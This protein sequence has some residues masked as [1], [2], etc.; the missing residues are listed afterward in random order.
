MKSINYFLITALG[1]LI[2]IASI[3]QKTTYKAGNAFSFTVNAGASTFASSLAWMH[4]RGVGKHKRLK[5]GYGLRFTS[6]AGSDIEFITA[7]AKFTSG[8]SSIAALV[9]P[10]INANI[11]TVSFA[12]AQINSLNAGIYFA[13][14]LPFWK[15]KVELGVNIDAVGFS[16]GGQQKGL[17]KNN[18]VSAKPTSFNLLLISDSDLGSLNSEWYVSY[19]FT[20]KVA[21]KVGYEFLFNEYTTT[22]KV[23]QL[24]SSNQTNDRFRL[25]S[26]MIM[27]GVNF[28]PFR[29]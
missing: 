15:N 1:L 18:E 19:Q 13:Y 21:V 4:Y 11:D 17:Y 3:A 22:T 16:F 9:S 12:T 20:K 27:L 14:T 24:P 28:S 2:S 10:N 8:K 6:F 26:G 29:K 5:V 25:K 7:P 23:Q